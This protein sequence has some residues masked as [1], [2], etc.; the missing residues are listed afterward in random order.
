MFNVLCGLNARA[1]R[2]WRRRL[3]YR[4]RTPSSSPSWRLQ[5]W[6]TIRARITKF[7]P[8]VEL[9]ER[10]SHT[11]LDVIG[12]FRSPASRR[13]V[14]YFSNLSVQLRNGS[15]YAP[16]LNRRLYSISSTSRSNFIV[17]AQFFRLYNA[18]TFSSRPTQSYIFLSNCANLQHSL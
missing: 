17:L 12:Y 2:S 16:N 4:P 13:C 9:D 15:T 10:C 1:Q 18:K 6:D 14:N 5:R 8:E 11:K 3:W 7:G